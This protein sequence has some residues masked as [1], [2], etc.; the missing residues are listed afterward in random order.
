MLKEND[1]IMK[2]KVYKAPAARDIQMEYL[3]LQASIT[4]VVGNSGIEIGTG[5]TP[6]T[7]DSRRHR[8]VWDVEEGDEW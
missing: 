6:T 8:S 7:A 5:E 1:K 4:D 2:T 3:L